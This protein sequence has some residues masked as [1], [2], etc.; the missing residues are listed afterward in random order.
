MS[1]HCLAWERLKVILSHAFYCVVNYINLYNKVYHDS[2]VRLVKHCQKHIVQ[3]I[4]LSNPR[5]SLV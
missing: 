1:L 3:R 5:K 4:I 2:V